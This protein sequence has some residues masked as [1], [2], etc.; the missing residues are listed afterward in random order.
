MSKIEGSLE[1]I[2]QYNKLNNLKLKP[3]AIHYSNIL[4]LYHSVYIDYIY[5]KH[6]IYSILNHLIYIYLIIQYLK[7]TKHIF[8]MAN[9][10]KY[11][12]QNI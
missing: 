6:Y 2:K 5:I 3:S 7:I 10:A 12:V 11:S 4:I 1:N 9:C 8:K